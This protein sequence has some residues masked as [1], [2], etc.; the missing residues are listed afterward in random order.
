MAVFTQVLLYSFQRSYYSHYIIIIIIIITVGGSQIQVQDLKTKAEENARA[1]HTDK[2]AG[3]EHDKLVARRGQEFNI[4][5]YF[6]K[7]FDPSTDTLKL[8]FTLGELI[9][10]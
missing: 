10:L 5:I 4:S 2:F 6:N 8:I 7:L 3:V 9:V 1:H